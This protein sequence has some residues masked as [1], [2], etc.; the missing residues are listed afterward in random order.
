MLKVLIADDH[1]FIRQGIKLIL[2]EEYPLAHFEEAEDADSLISKASAG[3]WDIILS[4]IS[5]PGGGGIHALEELSRQELRIPVLIVSMFPEEQY[6]LRVR[7]AGAVGYIT[8]DTVNENLVNAVQAVLAGQDYF[9]D[10][11]AKI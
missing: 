2:R 8:K 6:A 7:K 9:S 11:I 5:M 10:S 4:D 3:N 1:E